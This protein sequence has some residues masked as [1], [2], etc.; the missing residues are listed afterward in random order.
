MAKWLISLPP[1]PLGDVLKTDSAINLSVPRDREQVDSGLRQRKEPVSL[2]DSVKEPLLAPSPEQ[3]AYDKALKKAHQDRLKFVISAW[4]FTNFSITSTLGLY[5]L[6]TEAWMTNPVQY[7]EGY[8]SHPMS[9][10]LKLF[11]QIGFASYAY[12]TA[13]VFIEPRQK[14]FVFMVVHH[15]ATLF[16]IH[17]SYLNGFFRIG[18]AIL[19]CHEVS[20]PFMEIA[21]MFLY[22]GANKVIMC[23]PVYIP[24]ILILLRICLQ[25]ADVFFALFAG[26]F[27]YTRNYIF[28]V[29]IIASIPLYAYDDEGNSLAGE[30][31]VRHAAIFALCILEGL[32]I[33]WASLVWLFFFSIQ[34]NTHHP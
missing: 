33:Y 2:E 10:L 6:A 7:F 22:A 16:L 18:S 9:P 5:L 1:K 14:D 19:L 11:Y 21:K 25:L 30:D 34:V 24:D 28:P 31:H 8:G 32:H 3:S 23:F 27:I 20:D 13:S 17:M 26:V 15:I 12:A 29:Y 4:K